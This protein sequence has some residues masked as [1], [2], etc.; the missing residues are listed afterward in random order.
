MHVHTGSLGAVDA[1][2]DSRVQTKQADKQ[3]E[4]QKKKIIIQI[5]GVHASA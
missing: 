2:V 1:Y 3:A 4:Q 5:V